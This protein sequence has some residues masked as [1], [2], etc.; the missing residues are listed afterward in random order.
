MLPCLGN[1]TEC[2]DEGMITTSGPGAS[3]P[4]PRSSD[5]A[6]VTRIEVPIIIALERFFL[7]L[8][9]RDCIGRKAQN[10]LLDGGRARGG[11]PVGEFLLVHLKEGPGD[12]RPA[13]G[14]PVR[15]SPSSSSL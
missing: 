2:R 4:P 7:F 3:S 9:L 5:L 14:C 10:D 8:G 13:W 11:G 6:S 15:F 12:L 1:R